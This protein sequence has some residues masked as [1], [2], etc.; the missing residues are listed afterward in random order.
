MT[1]LQQFCLFLFCILFAFKFS[2]AETFN[3]TKISHDYWKKQG[4]KEKDFAIEK[5]A[6]CDDNVHWSYTLGKL[7]KTNFGEFERLVV[8][9]VAETSNMGAAKFHFPSGVKTV[10]RSSFLSG[11][12]FSGKIP[13]DKIQ[14]GIFPEG[15]VKGKARQCLQYLVENAD[16]R[17]I[18]NLYDGS[19]KSKY[20]LSYWEKNNFLR[21][22]KDKQGSFGH[23]TQIKGFDYD[24]EE[25]GAESIYKDVIAIIDQIASVPGNALIHC[26]GGMHRTGIVFG[27]MQKCLNG[28]KNKSQNKKF[29]KEVVGQEYKC[30]TDY[31][32]AEK[33]GGYHQENMTVIEKF[34]CDRLHKRLS[35]KPSSTKR[36]DL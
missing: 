14:K 3:C 32:S 12:I 8:L 11:K 20:V 30:H 9:N 25:R 1:N 5:P 33:I 15:K 27:V 23:Y 19:F 17:Q 2:H 26:Y 13:Y 34:P 16:I 24:L 28:P 4:K 35:R 18:V 21:S 36:I 29:V 22:T 10:Y 6:I 31:Q 7:R